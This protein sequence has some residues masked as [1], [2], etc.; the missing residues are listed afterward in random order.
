MT[1]LRCTYLGLEL[2]S[3]LIASATPLAQTVEGVRRLAEG[4]V[5]AVILPSLFEEQLRREA[6]EF[7]E[8][9]E[10]GS[11]SFAES[12]SY[13]PESPVDQDAPTRYLSLVERGA[14]A[15][16]VPIIGSLNGVTPGGWVRYA[17]S[18]QDA[19]AS[20]IELNVYQAPG[21]PSASGRE[22]EDRTIEVVREV[23]AAVSVPVAVKLGPFWSSM[24]EL[25]L[26]LDAAGADA[27]VLFNRFLQ[28]EIDPDTLTARPGIDLSTPADGRLAATWISLLRGR[29]RAQLA[30]S[31]GV[32]RAA[33][34]ARYLLAGADVVMTTSALMRH[35]PEHATALLEG[36][37]EWMRGKGYASLD[38]VRGVM[39][40]P[41]EADPAAYGREG[42]VSM[43]RPAGG[44]PAA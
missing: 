16:D 5:A 32:D 37:T 23:K 30:A 15:V 1:D 17:R 22:I 31:R 38:D 35:G 29:V 2:R 19:G 33:D 20:A 13:F 36:L 4:G 11:E 42:Y 27:L 12:L 24:G 39:S 28:P 8:L 40:V 21:P 34:V 26:R 7:H 41:A 44:S 3:P 18:I 10:A 9:A 14:A 25:A 43:V 6:A